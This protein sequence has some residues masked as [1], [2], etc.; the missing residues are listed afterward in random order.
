VRGL[1]RDGPRHPQVR[2][3]RE[4]RFLGVEVDATAAPRQ[5]EPFFAAADR[6]AEAL[7]A[8]LP[9]APTCEAAFARGLE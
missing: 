5:G 8:G 2:L 9:P 3:A 1:W 6:R 4:G 7:R